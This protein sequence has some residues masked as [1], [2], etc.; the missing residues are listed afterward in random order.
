MHEI[1][2]FTHLIKIKSQIWRRRMESSSSWAEVEKCHAS[3]VLFPWH[4]LL[5][6][7]KISIQSANSRCL[8]MHTFV[9]ICVWKCAG[10]LMCTFSL[11]ILLHTVSFWEYLIR[12][13]HTDT[14]YFLFQLCKLIYYRMIY[15][16]FYYYC[17]YLCI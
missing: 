16:E 15:L 3:C 13:M 14:S 6:E 10:I 7:I 9:S 1:D 17:K 11:R 8:A 5:E 4:S 12:C 2:H